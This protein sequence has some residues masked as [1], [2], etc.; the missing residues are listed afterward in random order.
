LVLGVAYWAYVSND[1]GGAGEN[2]DDGD[3]RRRTGFYANA[4]AWFLT[5]Q[6]AILSALG[7][8]RRSAEGPRGLAQVAVSKALDAVG[9]P[10]LAQALDDLTVFLCSLFALHLLP[11]PRQ[12][13]L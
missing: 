3:V 7:P 9:W 8:E 10:I 1:F 2:V 13:A 4:V 6:V 12:D 5:Y 11:W